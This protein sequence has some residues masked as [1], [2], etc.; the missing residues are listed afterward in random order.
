MVN[1]AVVCGCRLRLR[2]R[3]LII[4]RCPSPLFTSHNG[5]MLVAMTSLYPPVLCEALEVAG[6]VFVVA[7]FV[8]LS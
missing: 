2:C 4:V 5:R 1:V 8:A 7:E 6:A 3:L